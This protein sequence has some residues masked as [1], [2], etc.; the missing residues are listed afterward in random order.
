MPTQTSSERWSR[1]EMQPI[2]LYVFDLG[3]VDGKVYLAAN[4]P[5]DVV[6]AG[7][8]YAACP[9]ARSRTQQNARTEEDSLSIRIGNVD[10]RY[11][12]FLAERDIRGSSVT[13]QA[14]FADAIDEPDEYHIVFQG[15]IDRVA[16]DE[17]GISIDCFSRNSFQ[18]F[19]FP[20]RR[21]QQTCQ[22]TFGD[23]WCG[24]DLSTLATTPTATQ[25]Y[26]PVRMENVLV[27]TDPSGATSWSFVFVDLTQ[28][29]GHWHGGQVQFHRLYGAPLLRVLQRHIA[30]FTSADRRVHLDM[31]IIPPPQAGDGFTILRGCGKTWEACAIR[32]DA[33]YPLPLVEN[34]T[35]ATEPPF[36]GFRHL[37]DAQRKPIL[38]LPIE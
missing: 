22:W 25:P 1:R 5:D 11:S 26:L 4:Q 8:S 7:V 27:S 37:R 20:Q 13:V 23:A 31:P 19:A 17:F 3:E 33:Y 21:Y 36:S 35:I 16:V 24:V 10:R 38:F 28:R 9:I 15:I 18:H 32:T 30:L 2:E 34:G 6:F 12:E 14:V 29:D